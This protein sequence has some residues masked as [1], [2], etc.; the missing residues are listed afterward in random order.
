MYDTDALAIEAGV[1]A[2][3]T[4]AKDAARHLYASSHAQRQAFLTHLADSLRIDAEGILAANARDM[5]AAKAKGV[6]QALLDRLF[7][8]RKRL[9]AIADSLSD[10]ALQ[11]DPVGAVVEEWC[12]PN[13]LSFQAVRVPIGVIGIIYEARPNVTIDAAALCIKSGNAAVLR[14]GSESL[15]TALALYASI[16]KALVAAELPEH[17][18]QCLDTPDRAAVGALLRQDSTVD[19]IIPRGG[20]NLI[21]RVKSDSRI[22]VLSHLDGLCHTYIDKAA[23]PVKVLGVVLNAKMRRTG[24][25]GATETLLV[26]QDALHFLPPLLKA[27]HQSG[28]E[29]RGDN[30]VRELDPNIRIAV[31]EDWHME[32]LA[33]ILSIKTV[34]NIDAAITHINHYGSHHTDAI[35]TEDTAA[36]HKFLTHVDSG[37]VMVNT[38]TQFADGGEFG[39]GAEIGIATGKLHARGPVGARHLTT[40]QYRVQSDGACRGQ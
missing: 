27:L 36:A 22:P 16:R 26:H 13:G 31:E 19:L 33:P 10:I 35:I 7:L 38:S 20:R 3:T 29:L 23:D 17:A 6:S 8:D 28:C 25:C 12:R 40:I 9:Y 18:V 30:T 1:V 15:C 32:Y 4:A 14:P 5:T 11:P 34:T 39:F 21:E 2:L 24:I 37:I